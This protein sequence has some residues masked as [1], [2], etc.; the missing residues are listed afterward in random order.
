MFRTSCQT[1]IESLNKNNVGNLTRRKIL[2]VN[3][4]SI[5]REIR[6]LF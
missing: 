1:L 5:Q 6:L 2:D 4:T 3:K